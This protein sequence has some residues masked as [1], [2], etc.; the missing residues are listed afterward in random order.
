MACAT[1]RQIDVLASAA[2]GQFGFKTY[3]INP[4]LLPAFLGPVLVSNFA[5]ALAEKGYEPVVD[6][7]DA[8]V[9]LR[10]V[11]E[12]IGKDAS[13]GA[14]KSAADDAFAERIAEGGETRFIARFVVEI[15]AKGESDIQW[16]G[17]VQRLHTIRAGDYMHMGPASGAFLAAFRELLTDYPMSDGS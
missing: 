11:Q 8:V 3:E 13:H 1:P 6:R 17:S 15:R 5:V 4:E 16:Q 14:S 9:T 2:P 12:Q 7:G 10:L